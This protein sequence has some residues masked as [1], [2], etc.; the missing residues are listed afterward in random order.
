MVVCVVVEGDGVILRDCAPV[1]VAN[2][3]SWKKKKVAILSFRF[4][5][6]KVQLCE[7][8]AAAAAAAA[9]VNH[10]FLRNFRPGGKKRIGLEEG[11]YFAQIDSA[12]ENCGTLFFS[13]WDIPVVAR[14][15]A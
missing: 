7:T 5:T 8:A 14:Y 6:K 2:R 11:D 10:P 15:D 1:K 4:G 9:A 3:D 12:C 13:L